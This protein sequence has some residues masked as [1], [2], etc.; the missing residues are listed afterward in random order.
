VPATP[1]ELFER[2]TWTG[3]IRDADARAEMFAVDGVLE[4]PLLSAGHPHPRRLEGR[5]EIRAGLAGYY[6][7][8]ATDDRTVNADKSRYVLHLT[9]DPGVF[10]AEID[11]A[12]DV[13]GTTMT[14]SLVQIF[15]VRDGKITLMRD[16]F[17]PDAAD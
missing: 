9:T 2:Y 6:Q 17:A 4:A 13:A 7:R 15:R 5:E 8:S 10:I 11:A 14:M 12:L 1:Q 3:M 16:Y